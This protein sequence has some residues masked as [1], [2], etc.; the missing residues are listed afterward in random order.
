MTP[1]SWIII[2]L[3]LLAVILTIFSY[4]LNKPTDQARL[5][6]P[7]SAYFE[8]TNIEVKSN[9][10]FVLSAVVTT[11]TPD[12]GGSR[13]NIEY[14]MDMLESTSAEPNAF[15]TYNDSA[16]TGGVYT[17]LTNLTF[18]ALSPGKTT[19]S[20]QIKKEGAQL[21]VPG[22]TPDSLATVVITK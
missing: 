18:K 6:S 7:V 4:A 14:D 21:T 1:R 17:C 13:L 2:T 15:C 5:V 19:V 16:Q 20:I 12:V 22:E 8:Q 9:E 11:T 10:Q 3:A